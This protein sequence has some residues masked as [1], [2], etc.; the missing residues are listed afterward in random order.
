ME[1]TENLKLELLTID[2]IA[3]SWKCDPVK[4]PQYCQLDFALTRQGVIK[5]F[6]EVKCRSFESTRYKTALIHLHKMMY[7]RQVAFETNIPTFLIVRWTD[8][9][10]ACPFSVDFETTIGGRWDRGIERD[11]GLMAEVPMDKFQIIK[12]LN[13]PF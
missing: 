10:A 8:M 4:L 3:K 7:A 9:I 5:A 1:T 13:E 11:Y 2:A 12:V 6:A